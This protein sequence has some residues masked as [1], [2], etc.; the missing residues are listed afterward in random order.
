MKENKLTKVKLEAAKIQKKAAAYFVPKKGTKV[1]SHCEIRLKDEGRISTRGF[2][3]HKTK[4]GKVNNGE[5][6]DET[7]KELLMLLFRNPK[8]AGIKRVIDSKK[9]NIKIEVRPTEKKVRY[10]LDKGLVFTLRKVK[11]ED[12]TYDI[13]WPSLIKAQSMMEIELIKRFRTTINDFTICK[14]LIEAVVELFSK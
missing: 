6:F 9:L 11:K 7:I 4:D 2:I 10:Y 14:D 5:L 12:G 3:I 8:I 1:V 13:S